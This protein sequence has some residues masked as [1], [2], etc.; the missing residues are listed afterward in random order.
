M[1]H[2]GSA[3]AF[4][5]RCGGPVELVHVSRSDDGRRAPGHMALVTTDRA[6]TRLLAAVAWVEGAIVRS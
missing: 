4:A 2:P 6:R 1:C 3:D 5:R